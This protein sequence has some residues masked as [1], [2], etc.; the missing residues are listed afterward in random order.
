VRMDEEDPEN[1]LRVFGQAVEE[2]VSIEASEASGAAE[3]PSTTT[4]RSRPPPPFRRTTVVTKFKG[5]TFDEDLYVMELV[6]KSDHYSSDE[7]PLYKIGKSKE[8]EVRRHDLA[9]DFSQGFWVSTLLILKRCGD[10]EQSFHRRLQEH[11]CDVPRHRNGKELSKSREVFDLQK[12]AGEEEGVVVT[13]L[14]ELAEDI[15]ASLD[16]PRRSLGSQEETETKRRRCMD[17]ELEK[18]KTLQVMAEAD[19]RKAEAE[20]C[21]RKAEADARR[22]EARARQLELLVTLGTE[23]QLAL[24]HH[25]QQA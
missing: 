25:W 23:V 2:A 10:L 24:A 1:P 4:A 19:A 9:L 16:S 3:T 17:L 20:A 12:W 6:P 7:H 15:V 14:L 18:E 11:R 8:V 21:A 5:T 13:Q 22:A